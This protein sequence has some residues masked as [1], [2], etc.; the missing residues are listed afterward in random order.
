MSSEHRVLLDSFA[1][2]RRTWDDLVA[3][4]P[5]VKARSGNLE[6]PALIEMERRIELTGWR[7]TCSRMP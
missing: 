7:W 6:E 5:D 2:A 1:D 3:L 4:Q